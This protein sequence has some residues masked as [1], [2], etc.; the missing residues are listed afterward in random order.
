[1]KLTWYCDKQAQIRAG[2]EPR[3][4]AEVDIDLASLTPEQRE[5]LAAGGWAGKL[6]HATPEEVREQLQ[7]RIEELA[8]QEAEFAEALTQ[9]RIEP[10]APVR[11]TFP[12]GVDVMLPR[13][14]VVG[15]PYCGVFGAERARRVDAIADPLRAEVERLNREAEAAAIEAAREAIEAGAEA[16]R[17]HTEREEAEKVAALAAK[18]ARRAELGAVEVSITRGGRE[19]GTPWGA[20]VTPGRGRE[21]YAF[22]AATYDLAREVLTIKCQPGA[23]IAWGQKNFSKP[24]RTIH[25]RR[26]VAADWRL[27]NM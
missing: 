23:V 9:I 20:V 21:D 25:E 17:L 11:R 18:L 2:V 7:A 15:C 16:E 4:M 3:D 13:V 8:R 14:Q 12:G 6:I 26:R 5:I 27:E 19:W 24:R 10:C 22:D 1:M